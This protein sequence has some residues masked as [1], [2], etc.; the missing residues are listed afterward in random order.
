V[1]PKLHPL[2][3]SELSTRLAVLQGVEH[4]AL[5]ALGLRKAFAAL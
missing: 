4:L 2:A 3:E 1:I 5:L